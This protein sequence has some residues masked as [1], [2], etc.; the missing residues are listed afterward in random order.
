MNLFDIAKIEVELKNLEN[1]TIE[2]NFWNNSKNSSKVLA[3][4]KAIKG[5]YIEYRR[6]ENEIA[7]LEELNELVELEPD[8]EISK[9]IFKNTNIL[10][11]DIEK[12]EIET[13]L[14][15]KY[16]P[17]NAIVTIHPGARRNRI[18]RL[19]RNAI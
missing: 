1:Q 4:M 10:K 7:N 2:P 3:K 16:D 14:Y 13:L 5:K 17:N 19:G 6:L 11:K 15:G 9:D 18:A 8:E 12:L